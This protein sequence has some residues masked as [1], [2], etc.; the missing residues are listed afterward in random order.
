TREDRQRAASYRDNAERH[1]LAAASTDVNGFLRDLQMH[2]ELKPFDAP[3]LP[4]IVQLIN[5]TNQ[6][7]LTTRRM[8]AAEV[9]AILK[10]PGCY[11]QFMRLRDRFGDSG[12]TGV[13]IAFEEADALRID[14]WLLSCRVLGRRIED[15]MLAAAHARALQNGLKYL[16]GEYIPTPKN[17]QVR[18]LYGRFGF[19]LAGEDSA[20]VRKYRLP[21][22]EGAFP[23]PDYC[24]VTWN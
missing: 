12:L 21:V 18:D 7:N 13:L 23:E 8:S 10:R 15:V 5:K 24:R 2:V 11:T 19:E 22:R 3:N 6:F 1:V 16:S 17:G 20:G 14:N 9:D 4:R